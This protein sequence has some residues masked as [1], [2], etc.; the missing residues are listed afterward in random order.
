MKSH[1]GGQSSHFGIGGDGER[2]S[3]PPTADPLIVK[4]GADKSVT[5]FLMSI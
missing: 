3:E 5:L 2:R 1:L 4:W